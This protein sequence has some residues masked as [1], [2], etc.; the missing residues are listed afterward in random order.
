MELAL[1]HWPFL[2]AML[3]FAVLTQVLKG[4][5]FTQENVVKY[6][7]KKH[8]LGELIW[9]GRK[10][11]PLHPVIFGMGLGFIPGVPVSAGVETIAA[12]VFYFA[13]AGLVSTW[14][15]AVVKSLAKKR[16]IDLEAVEDTP[17]SPSL[18]SLKRDGDE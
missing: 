9:W 8:V 17:T 6:K 2:A 1:S 16:G 15:F 5:V 13:F 7:T 4:T 12:K 14:A 18:P 10:S 3:F 11:L